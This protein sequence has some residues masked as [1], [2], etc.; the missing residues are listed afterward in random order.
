MQLN[1]EKKYVE[2]APY[3]KKDEMHLRDSQLF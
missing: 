1:E 3:E 2:E